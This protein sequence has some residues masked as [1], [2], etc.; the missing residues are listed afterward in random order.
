MTGLEKK[1]FNVPISEIQRQRL[2]RAAEI[3][4]HERGER[5]TASALFREL[6]LKA[7]DEILADQ[8]TTAAAS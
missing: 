5:I 8:P 4:S 7:V 3:I 6:G 1:S 2:D